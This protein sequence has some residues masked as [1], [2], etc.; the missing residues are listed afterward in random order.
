MQAVYS[1]IPS[2]T[3]LFLYFDVFLNMKFEVLFHY[4]SHANTCR[5]LLGTLVEVQVSLLHLN[6][7]VQ[8]SLSYCKTLRT[9]IYNCL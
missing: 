5:M 3:S 8:R 2:C 7:N 6:F 9:F 4:N 1:S